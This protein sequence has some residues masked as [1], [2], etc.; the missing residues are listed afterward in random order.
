MGCALSRV[1][2]NIAGQISCCQQ[3]TPCGVVSD[4]LGEGAL[5]EQ[6]RVGQQ[7]LQLPHVQP[8]WPRPSDLPRVA[9]AIRREDALERLTMSGEERGDCGRVDASSTEG[10]GVGEERAV[11]VVCPG[12]EPSCSAVKRPARPCKAP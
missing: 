5:R 11:P 12:R 1:G 8:S 7:R 9:G 2:A 10:G 4:S 3:P 6:R